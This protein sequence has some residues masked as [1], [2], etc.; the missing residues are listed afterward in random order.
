MNN[1]ENNK[2]ILSFIVPAYNASKTLQKCLESFLCGGEAQEKIEVIVVNDGS[3]DDTSVIGEEYVQKYPDVFK[4]ITQ[5]NGGHGEA[6]NTGIAE[7]C[8]KYIKCIDS[9]DWVVTENLRSWISRLSHCEADVVITP[10]HMV[11]ASTGKKKVYDFHIEKTNISVERVYGISD[12]TENFRAFVRCLSYHGVTFLRSTYNK[13]AHK[14]PRKVFYEDLEYAMVNCAMA[15]TFCLMDFFIYEYRVGDSEQSVST[16]SRLKRINDSWRVTEDMLEFYQSLELRKSAFM[17]DDFSIRKT[18]TY[19]M[20]E[21]MILSHYVTC[22]ILQPD[23][24][25]GCRD[26]R[27]YNQMILEKSPE[28]FVKLKKKRMVY[29]LLNFF[30]VDV[31]RYRALLDVRRKII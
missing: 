31:K 25:K 2:K 8:G 19:L 22:C 12:I 5:K 9:D 4:L 30:H 20:T 24:Q 6:L 17:E 7:A 10:F 18:F 14:L 15:K 28:I 11:D 1:L 26:F 16:N 29:A 21:Q 13:T 23:K 27:A 3:Q